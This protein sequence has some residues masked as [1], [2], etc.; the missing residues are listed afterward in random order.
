MSKY[1]HFRGDRVTPETTL[2]WMNKDYWREGITKKE[3]YQAAKSF[4]VF[5]HNSELFPLRVV[6]KIEGV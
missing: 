5:A 1:R 3:L 4:R 6:Q 2:D